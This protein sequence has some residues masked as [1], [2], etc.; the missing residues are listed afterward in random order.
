[1]L[2][3]LILSENHIQGIVFIGDFVET[4]EIEISLR[5][6]IGSSSARRERNSGLLPGV[7]YQPG[8]E[9]VS[10]VLD[11]HKFILSARGKATTQL[12][13][14]KGAKDFDGKLSLIKS[15]QT[16]PLKG[17]VLHVEFLAVDDSNK[18]IVNVP[19]R[20]IGMPECVRLNTAMVNQTAYEI[21]IECIPSK[22]P[23][24]IDLDISKMIGGDSLTASDVALLEGSSLKSRP[25]LTIVST[26]IDKRAMNAAAAAA[27]SD[28]K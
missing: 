19:V 10:V 11:K 2:I 18:V 22:I 3:C 24:S 20:L 23:S 9:S 12:F 4:V 27:K 26:L 28:G 5:D 25:G 14:F 13:K 15:V 17:N 8:K 6:K 21:S 7:I 1:V 16:E